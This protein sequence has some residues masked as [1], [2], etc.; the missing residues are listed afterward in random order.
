[1]RPLV[2]LLTSESSTAQ[3]KA[4]AV[5]ADLARASVRNKQTIL[6]EGGISPLVALLG[7]DQPNE[8]RAEAA[9]A[10]EALADQQPETQRI[11]ADAGALK[12]IVALLGE[13]DDLARVR[14]AGA[15]ASLC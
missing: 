10:L 3:A 9:G 2:A 13:K 5:L 15:I 12:A 4:S 14:S 1:M 11:V 8:T 6:S 7:K